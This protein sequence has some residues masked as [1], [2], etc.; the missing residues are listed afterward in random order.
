VASGSLTI[1]EAERIDIF[2]NVPAIERVISL[3]LAR[4]HPTLFFT[5]AIQKLGSPTAI[6]N[7]IRDNAAI[8]GRA[9]IGFPFRKAA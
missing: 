8:G 4:L 5:L 7:P 9:G 6:S 2:L 3:K 1:D